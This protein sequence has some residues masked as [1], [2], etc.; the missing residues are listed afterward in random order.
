MLDAIRDEMKSRS[1]AWH[2]LPSHNE[3]SC[4]H[5]QG[6]ET[7]TS[8]VLISSEAF[9]MQDLIASL[10]YG[11]LV[12]IKHDWL[13]ADQTFDMHRGIRNIEPQASGTY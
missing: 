10:G 5:P 3:T 4:Q 8:S 7:T 2:M 12:G 9:M 13:L 1:Q 11:M 6:S